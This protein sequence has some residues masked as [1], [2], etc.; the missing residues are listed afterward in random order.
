MKKTLAL[1][2]VAVLCLS[3][4]ACTITINGSNTNEIGG[5]DAP[6]LGNTDKEYALVA[7]TQ[8]NWQDYFEL[9]EY[10]KFEENGFG[11]TDKVTTYYTLVNKDG[12]VV[13]A[14]KSSVT[15]E[16]TCT[17]EEKTYVVNFANKTVTYGETINTK[18]TSPKV[19]TMN[20]VGQ[21]VGEVSR[22]KYGEYLGVCNWYDVRN[23]AYDV[24]AIDVLRIVG[25]L[26]IVQEP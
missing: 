26:A 22:D 1:I 10:H 20:S 12:I 15:F 7:I 25:N 13:N 23:T 8:D 24:V 16:F 9:R 4:I 5:S 19:E 21:Y 6:A 18:E 17:I 3:L 14:N 2:L 11:E